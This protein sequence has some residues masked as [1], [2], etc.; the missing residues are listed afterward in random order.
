MTR[1]ASAVSEDPAVIQQDLTAQGMATDWLIYNDTRKVCPDDDKL[2]QR[3]V[4]AVV[5]FST[6]GQKWVQCSADDEMLCGN[7]EPFFQ[8]QPFLSESNECQWAGISCNANACIT[9][10]EFGMCFC[11]S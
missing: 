1:L 8:Q 6:G 11:D 7:S 5:Y 9:E 3:W 2:V 4:M 10:I